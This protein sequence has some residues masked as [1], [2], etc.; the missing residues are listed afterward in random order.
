MVMFDI[1]KK[2]LKKVVESV[3]K[4]IE[5]K[6]EVLEPEEKHKAEKRLLKRALERVVKRVTKRILSE[7]DIRPILEELEIGLIEAD[8]ALEV[9]EKIKQDL[10]SSLVG[11]EIKRG[12]ERS[13]VINVLKKSLM[14]ILSAPEIDLKDLSKPATLL[15][16][17]FNGSGKTTSLAK[18]AKWLIANGY[19]CVFAAADT[20]RAAAI[21]QLEEHAKKLGVKVIKHK[22]GADPA[23]VVYDA[24][25]H[26]K[27]K[28][29]DFIL[30]DTAGRAHTNRDLMDEMEKIIRVNKPEL[31]ILVIDSLT[32]NDAIAQA[33]AFG[34]LGIDA[35]IFTKVD[36]NKKGGA[37][38]SVTYEL[39]KPIL[40]LGLGQKYE[41]LEKFNAEKFINRILE[42]S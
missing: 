33:R 10:Q 9:V 31:K 32:G 34:E 8:V 35:L 13:F 41:D 38:L 25:E 30:A 4:K 40:F 37:I 3:S 26:A 23:A 5:T 11:V 6:P 2:K 14:E 24:R 27:A 18:C 28:G 20:F 16:L 42:I 21:Q 7:K 22:Y 17:G 39:K 29:I 12:E 36:V 1:L 15:F 19:T